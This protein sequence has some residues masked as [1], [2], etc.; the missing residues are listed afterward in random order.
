MKTKGTA[1]TGLFDRTTLDRVMA[2][3]ARRVQDVIAQLKSGKKR[4]G[5]KLTP[6]EWIEVSIEMGGFRPAPPPQPILVPQKKRRD[7]GAQQMEF[8]FDGPQAVAPLHKA[9]RRQGKERGEKTA[10]AL[11]AKSPRARIQ[12][13]EP[14]E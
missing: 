13:K 6:Q 2:E 1:E 9:K 14:S 5:V 3:S 12:E 4:K 10:A 7:G 8:T 11:N